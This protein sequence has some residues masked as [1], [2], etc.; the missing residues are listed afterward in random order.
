MK[1][2]TDMEAVPSRMLALARLLAVANALF[3][4]KAHKGLGNRQEG[5]SKPRW[6]AG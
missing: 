2:Y 4:S 1:I 5:L 6:S 3:W